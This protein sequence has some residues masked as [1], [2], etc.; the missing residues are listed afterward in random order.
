MPHFPKPFW[1]KSRGAWYVEL[2]RKQHNL[3]P[4]RDEAFRRYHDLMARRET[5]EVVASDSLVAI[6]DAH[7]EWS[8]QNRAAATYS[9]YRDRLEKFARTYPQLNVG[10][11]R[12]YHIQQW[13]DGMEVASGTKRNYCRAVKRCMRWAKQQGYIDVNPVADLQMPRGGKREKV[14]SPEEFQNILRFA[15]DVSFRNLL[16]V[17]WE[18]GCRPQES[19]RVEARHVDIANQRWIFPASESKTDAIRI[20][21]L[22]DAALSITKQLMRQYPTGKL[23]RNSRGKPWTTEAVNCTFIR[24]QIAMGREL[25]ERQST[26]TNP[27]KRRK[28]LAVDDK[29]A[30][31]FMKTLNPEK[32]SGQRKSPAELRN[33]ARRKLTYKAA[34]QLAPKYSLY[35]LRHSWMNRLLAEGV[36]ALTVAFLAGH[37][38]TSTLAKTYA[39][40]NQNKAY[41]L[42]QAKRA[43]S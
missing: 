38:D 34:T 19:L 5:T 43:A 15:A 24:I 31:E 41:L 1:K 6:I 7:L 4:N 20:V 32:Q 23:F 35:V 10:E 27:D 36:D 12:P 30:K 22:T 14:V 33:E 40:L 21:Y 13:I 29:A 42:E 28:Y 17:T 2:N 39:H 9:W 8:Q 11:L 3:G 18:T 16:E 25:L 26:K 37:S